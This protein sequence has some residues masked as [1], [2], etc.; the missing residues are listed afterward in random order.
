V[1]LP[2]FASILLYHSVYRI[3]GVRFTR[4]GT[5][6]GFSALL[7][8]TVRTHYTVIILGVRWAYRRRCIEQTRAFAQLLRLFTR[9]TS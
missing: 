8:H 7:H 1:L 5:V 4:Y 6:R 9:E 3:H 2:L